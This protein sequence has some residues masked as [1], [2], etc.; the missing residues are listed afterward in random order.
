MLQTRTNQINDPGDLMNL[1][2]G[3]ADGG[4]VPLSSIA[5]ISEEGVAAELERTA[6]RRSIEIDL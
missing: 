4:L 3:S 1:Y 5:F 6:Q 2:V